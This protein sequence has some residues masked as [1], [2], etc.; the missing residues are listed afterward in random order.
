MIDQPTDAVLVDEYCRLHF[1]IE[2]ADSPILAGTRAADLSN[3]E[4]PTTDEIE[5]AELA[6][7]VGRHFSATGTTRRRTP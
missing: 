2:P 5:T 4:E 6:A 7:Y 3:D 1:G